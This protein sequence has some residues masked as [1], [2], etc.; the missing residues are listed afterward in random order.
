M[1]TVFSRY[2]QQRHLPDP[3]IAKNHPGD[4]I[5]TKKHQNWASRLGIDPHNSDR[6]SSVKISLSRTNYEHTHT[7]T[8]YKK[9][10]RLFR[11]FMRL[12]S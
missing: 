11:F 9:I 7:G 10:Y 3:T 5:S 2:Q 6:Q 1:N 12:I 4:L 8:L